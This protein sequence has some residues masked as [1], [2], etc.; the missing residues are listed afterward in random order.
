VTKL[1]DLPQIQISS[2]RTS[3]LVYPFYEK[4]GFVLVEVV[5]DYWAPGFDL[6]RM[7]Y[8]GDK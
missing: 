2:V 3:Q 7:I 1:K 6:Y 8:K 5:T 4:N